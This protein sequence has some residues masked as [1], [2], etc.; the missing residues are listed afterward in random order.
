M[1]FVAK[2]KG[3]GMALL[4]KPVLD[5]GLKIELLKVR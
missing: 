3:K 1:N 4:G 5:H 2:V